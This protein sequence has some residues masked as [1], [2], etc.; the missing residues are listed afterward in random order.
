MRLNEGGVEGQEVGQEKERKRGQIR[1]EA[2]K[3]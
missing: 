2:G 1:S 3:T